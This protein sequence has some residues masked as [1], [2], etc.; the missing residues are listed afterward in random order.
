[1]EPLLDQDL[2]VT[3][4]SLFPLRSSVFP[5]GTW[6][7]CPGE[8]TL[9][10]KAGAGHPNTQEYPDVCPRQAA[11]AWIQVLLALDSCGD[12]GAPLPSRELFMV[13]TS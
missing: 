6:I 12:L 2:H 9:L 7:Q 13:P 4:A 10:T 1:M 5:S 3:L 11:A 8:L